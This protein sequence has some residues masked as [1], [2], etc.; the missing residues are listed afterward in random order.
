MDRP[1][2]IADRL[3]A[4]GFRLAGVEACVTEPG[5]VRQQFR[6]ALSLG[7]P[8]L[9][10]ADLAAQI[11]AAELLRAI[12]QAQPVVAVIP[13][14][15]GQDAVMDMRSRVLRALGVEA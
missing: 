12:S 13:D 7:R 4:A 2:L 15:G 10:S 3:T 14:I 9:I 6:Q 11:P 5:E 1:L 8:L